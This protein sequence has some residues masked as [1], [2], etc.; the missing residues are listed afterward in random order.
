MNRVDLAKI[1]QMAEAEYLRLVREGRVGLRDAWMA[2]LGAG[3]YVAAIA[4]GDVASDFVIDHRR[5]ICRV[6]DSRRHEQAAEDDAVSDWCGDPLK[7]QLTAVLPTCGCLIAGKTAVASEECPQEKW[8][9]VRPAEVT[10]SAPRAAGRGRGPASAGG[11]GRCAP[12][13]G[14]R[15]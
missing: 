13:A 4:L 12:D 5:A 7:S 1:M 15:R 9:K 14:A 8:R 2:A 6:C 3:K 11:A 10:I